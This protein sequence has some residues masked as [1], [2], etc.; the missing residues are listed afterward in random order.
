VIVD[1]TFE[2]ER[3][4]HRRRYIASNNITADDDQQQMPSATANT[5]LRF[6]EIVTPV[7]VSSSSQSRQI[8]KEDGMIRRAA[9]NT[10][11]WIKSILLP[12]GYPRT[13]QSPD[14]ARYYS[15]LFVQG[16][17]GSM[18]YYMSMDA[19]LV[20]LNASSAHHGMSA[21]VSW[22]VKDGIGSFGTMFAAKVF[23]DANHFDSNTLRAKFRA[24]IAHN[25]GVGLEL[26]THFLPTFFIPLAASANVVK[27]VAGLTTGACRVAINRQLATANN[28]GD[29]TAK[30]HA[31]GIG[32]YL[33]GLALGYA[34]VSTIPTLVGWTN[35]YLAQVANAYPDLP[36]LVLSALNTGVTNGVVTSVVFVG[37]GAVHLWASYNALRSVAL[38]SINMERASILIDQFLRI[39]RDAR[40][41][42]DVLAPQDLRQGQMEYILLAN[43]LIHSRRPHIQL[44]SSIRETFASQEQLVAAV[45]TFASAMYLIQWRADRSSF[46]VHFHIDAQPLDVLE[47]FIHAYVLREEQ[48]ITTN[49]TTRTQSKEE[50]HAMFD[51]FVEGLKMKGWHLGEILLMSNR[52][53]S[54]S[55]WSIQ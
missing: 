50:F 31:Q 12:V 41:S 18:T 2:G 38:R 43:P 1:E 40:S 28:L 54:R 6:N 9:R 53:K 34:I 46:R 4:V 26:A 15:W 14:Y 52:A 16:V 51:Q 36:A 20:A 10:K 27:G 24:D 23:G 42:E 3:D 30:G 35:P 32:A 19:L 49:D 5:P 7:G 17:A 55:K 11:D 8:S 13:V 21:V 33:T 29:V 47:G 22:I 48:S 44:G 37:A 45:E 39:P 25:V